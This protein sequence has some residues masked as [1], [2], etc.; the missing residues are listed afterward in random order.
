[1]RIWITELN[2]FC[3]VSIHNYCA[4]GTVDEQEPSGDFEREYVFYD[5]PLKSQAAVMSGAGCEMDLATFAAFRI[6]LYE[7][8]DKYNAHDP[9]SGLIPMWDFSDEE[10]EELVFGNCPYVMASFKGPLGHELR[11]EY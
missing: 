7:A 4:D 5:N 9:R 2:S 3:D 8:V 10:C 1:M 6:D 11:R